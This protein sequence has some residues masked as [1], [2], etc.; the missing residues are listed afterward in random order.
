[1]IEG[2]VRTSVDTESY[3]LMI[4]F[5]QNYAIDMMNSCNPFI[6]STDSFAVGMDNDKIISNARSSIIESI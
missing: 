4:T 1:M 6:D 3:K 5:L 2:D